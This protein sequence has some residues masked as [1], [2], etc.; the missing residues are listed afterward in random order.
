MER[1]AVQI[2]PPVASY[3]NALVWQLRKYLAN[4]K[5]CLVLVAVILP[6][7]LK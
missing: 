3:A 7:F 5:V 6:M 2:L 4:M 1:N